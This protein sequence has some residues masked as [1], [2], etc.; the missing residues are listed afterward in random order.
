MAVMYI[1][2]GIRP[3]RPNH[4]DC[5]EPLWTLTQRCWSKEPQDRPEMWEVIEVLEDSSTPTPPQKGGREAR[6]KRFK[7]RYDQPSNKT[8]F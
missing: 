8:L 1:M 4:P 2:T 3:E 7:V 5:T 6:E